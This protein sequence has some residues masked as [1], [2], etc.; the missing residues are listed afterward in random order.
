[1]ND[2]GLSSLAV[3]DNSQNVIG[4]ISTTDV[5]H[6]TKTS[7]LR[8][9]K[10]SCIHFISVIL[11]SRGL[12]D[13]KD[14]FPVFYVNPYST[15]AHTVAKLVATT[16]QRMWVTES[17]SPSPSAPPTPA[18]VPSVLVVPHSNGPN[19]PPLSP[20]YPSISASA[21]PGGRMSGCLIG[22]VSLTD[23]L[24]L[25]ARQSGL[26]TSD[27]SEERTYRRRSSSVSL[28]PS[29]D[30]GRGSSVDMRR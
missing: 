2:E 1:M 26:Q 14:S 24:N 4:N 5:K 22:V 17:P 30:S 29:I 25:F 13:G 3:V 9:L 18:A 16:S 28:R 11:S 20:S 19:T 15:L 6:L 21:F 12:D 27:P 23:V 8:L 7:A 10:S